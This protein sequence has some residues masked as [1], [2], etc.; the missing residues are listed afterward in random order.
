M[1]ARLIARDDGAFAVEGELDFDSVAGLWDES[2]RLFQK[3]P[4]RIDLAG[5]KH[6]N[7]AGVA[8]LVEWLREAKAKGQELCFVNIPPQMVSIIEVA[9]LN[10]LPS[11]DC[12]V[13]AADCDAT[14]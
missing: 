4:A 2:L 10:D 12:R 5:V 14:D 9:D 7:S 8:L 6:S 11:F 13:A 1:P 3:P